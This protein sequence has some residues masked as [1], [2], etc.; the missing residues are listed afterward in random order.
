MHFYTYSYPN[1]GYWTNE[2]PYYSQV[3]D[4]EMNVIDIRRKFFVH[5]FGSFF[6][7]LRL[8]R[9]LLMFNKHKLFQQQL[10]I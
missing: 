5:I 1:T 4:E 7:L 10:Q 6:F 9:P 2:I 3:Y 8:Y